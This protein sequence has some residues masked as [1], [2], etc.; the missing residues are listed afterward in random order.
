MKK[1]ISIFLIATSLLILGGCAKKFDDYFKDSNR[2][3]DVPAALY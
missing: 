1:T 2:P 3:E